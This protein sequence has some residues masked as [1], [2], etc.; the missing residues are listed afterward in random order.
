MEFNHKHFHAIIFCDF[1]RG[2]TWQQC[3]DEL[4]LILGNEVPS[5]SNVFDGMVN[6]IGIVDHSKRNFVKVVQNQWLF[7]IL[8]KRLVAIGREKH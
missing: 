2:L 3:I 5:R 4:N 1:R 8:Q 6:A 7:L